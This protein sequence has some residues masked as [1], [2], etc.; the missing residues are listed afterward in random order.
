MATFQFDLVSPEKL[1]FSGQVEQVDI[2]G[3]EGDLGILAGHAPLVAT[4]RP[5][6]VAVR[7]GSDTQRIVVFGGV[8]EVSPAGLTLLA[9]NATPVGEI[10]AA[11]IAAEIKNAEEDIADT[12]DPALRDKYARKVGQ[13]RAIQAALSG[14]H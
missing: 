8:A 4:L 10:D 11:A 7:T 2:P 1:L 9:D 13:L 6:I 12:A 14:A 5:G 3:S